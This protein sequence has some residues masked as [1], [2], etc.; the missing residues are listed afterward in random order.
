MNYKRDITYAICSIGFKRFQNPMSD[1][2]KSASKV[3]VVPARVNHNDFTI[4]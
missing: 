2:T 4:L 1:Q 3:V